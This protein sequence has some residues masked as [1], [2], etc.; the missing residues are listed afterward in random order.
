MEANNTDKLNTIIV[1]DESDEAGFSF[2]FKCGLCGYEWRSAHV[3]F[4]FS[5]IAEIANDEKE[6]ALFWVEEREKAYN[7]A[8]ENA[9]IEFNRCPDCGTWV[10]DN[11]FYVTDEELTDFCKECIEKL[12]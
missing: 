12:K 11:C 6:Q 9:A 10:C 2:V 5:H 4:D 7:A 8:K 3:P 1:K